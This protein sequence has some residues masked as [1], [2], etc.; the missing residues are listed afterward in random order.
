MKIFLTGASGFIGKNLIKFSLKKGHFIFANTSHRN[1]KKYKRLKWLFGD[2]D[3]N[4]KKELKKSDILIHLAA[5]GVNQQKFSNDIYDTNI[6]KSLNLLQNAIRAGC[7]KWII[8]STSS[9]YGKNLKIKKNEFDIKTNRI[10]DNDYGMSKAILSDQCENLA[11]KFKCQV[12]IM[13]IFPTFGKGENKKRLYPSL[14]HAIK[15]N[16]NFR[17]ITPNEK[18]DFTRIQFVCDTILDTCNFDKRNFKFSQKWHISENNPKFVKKF[19]SE[20]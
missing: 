12:R 20:I 17:I 7:K 13:R 9:E 2:F 4:W 16:K 10:P 3:K 5:G 1:K 8:V 19:V 14:I 6:F 18:R 11:K 15:K